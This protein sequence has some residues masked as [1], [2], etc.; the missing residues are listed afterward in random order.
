MHTSWN[1][2]ED[3]A[4]Q[5]EEE[6]VDLQW[7]LTGDDMGPNYSILSSVVVR[8]C[9]AVCGEIPTRWPKETSSVPELEE[10]DAA[11]D[12]STEE[13]DDDHAEEYEGEW[14]V[15]TEVEEGDEDEEQRDNVARFEF[16]GYE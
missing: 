9:E 5:Y 10:W 7:S 12:E 14:D 3:A 6:I 15:E 1:I 13:E 11:D 16:S 2:S 8:S 4:H